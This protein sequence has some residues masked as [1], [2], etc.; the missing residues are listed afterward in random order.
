M[1]EQAQPGRFQVRAGLLDG[2][3]YVEIVDNLAMSGMRFHPEL[4]LQISH[5]V[6]KA[7]F[8]AMGEQL[9]GMT[10]QVHHPGITVA[11]N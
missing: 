1:T 6:Q 5:M 2:Q 4:A 8:A 11:K 3:P 7:V 10:R 9:R